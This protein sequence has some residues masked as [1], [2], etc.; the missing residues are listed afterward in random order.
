[1]VGRNSLT[2][3]KE[4]TSE[5]LEC[6]EDGT[7]NPE[8]V[9]FSRHPLHRCN[10]KGSWGR[11]KRWDYWCVTSREGALSITYADIDYIG[12]ATVSFL[13]FETKEFTEKVA[14]VTL[15]RGFSQPETVAGSDVVFN[16]S[17]LHFG[18]HE[19][20]ERARVVV[21]FKKLGGP[22]V[23]AELEVDRPATHETLNVLVPWSDTRFQFS[24]RTPG[25]NP[26]V[27]H[28]CDVIA[29][30]VGL[31]HVMRR[32]QDRRVMGIAQFLDE[33]LYLELGTRVQPC[34]RLVQ[35]KQDGRCQQC[36]GDGNL[37]LLTA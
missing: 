33:G 25:N 15:A 1:M 11:K 12:L 37:L 27:V 26:A 4:I 6:L 28:N 3:E 10:L 2:H 13:D 17:G 14:I 20:Q 32:Q 35:Q 19:E 30:G 34:G 24:R 7:L 8:A 22:H 29:Q 18:V 5:V 36:A 21:C 31:I 9:G 23:E 16:G